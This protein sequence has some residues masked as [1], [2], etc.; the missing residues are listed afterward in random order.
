[1]AAPVGALA[2]AQAQL[3]EAEQRQVLGIVVEPAEL[4]RLRLQAAD[5]LDHEQ[6]LR[7]PVRGAAL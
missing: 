1:M 6:A 4:E 3:R 7:R 2:A 5:A